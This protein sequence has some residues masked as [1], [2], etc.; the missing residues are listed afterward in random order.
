MHGIIT[1]IT[2]RVNDHKKVPSADWVVFQDDVAFQQVVIGKSFGKFIEF[3]KK[4]N[5]LQKVGGRFTKAIKKSHGDHK[6]CKSFITKKYC[7]ITKENV[8]MITH[9]ME[10]GVVDLQSL[11][12]G[13][14]SAKTDQGIISHD[15][16]WKGNLNVFATGGK[17]VSVSVH[18]T[19]YA[20]CSSDGR[21]HML[22]LHKDH[23][24]VNLY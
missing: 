1:K 23:A 3:A 18:F 17:P 19:K 9:F 13:P 11:P 4:K 2:Y 10:P 24:K 6:F 5:A 22:D 14:L 8:I 16:K 12:M 7:V 21:S 20:E 15:F